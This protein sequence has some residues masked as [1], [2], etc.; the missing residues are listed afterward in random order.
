MPN[1]AWNVPL[2]SQFF[3]KRSLVFS[4]LLFFSISLHCSL[5]KAFLPLL[6]ILWNSPFRWKYISF[7]PLRFASLL[8]TAIC[9]TSSDNHLAFLHFFFLRQCWSLPPVQYHEPP[10][11]VLQVLC[12]SDL[13]LWI[14]LPLLLYN[15][16]G[17]Y[18]GHTW[19]AYWFSLLSSI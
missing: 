17:F 12:L 15:H 16:K 19:M 2:V 13:I 14:Y 8:F 18:L 4:I 9:K 1:F 10:S 11:I 5:R 6:A 3:F 7:S